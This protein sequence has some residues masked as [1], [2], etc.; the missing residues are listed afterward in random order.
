MDPFQRVRGRERERAGQQL[1]QGDAQGVEIAPGIDRAVHAPGLLRG[2][3]GEGPGKNLRR[4]GR[5]ALAGEP[6]RHAEAGEPHVTRVVDEHVRRLDVPVDDTL[7][8]G[9][10]ERVGQT[11]G[12]AQ[13]AGQIDRLPLLALDDPIEGLTTGIVEDE[14]RSP[15]VTG[16]ARAAE[17]PI[18]HRAPL[19]A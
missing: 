4:R 9:L 18:A 17:R 12:D 5:Q 16:R 19:Q 8:V 1:V 11:D 7:P 2:H 3:V 6:R 10:S 13:E 15:F 14:G